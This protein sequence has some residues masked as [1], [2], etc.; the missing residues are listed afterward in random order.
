M[1]DGM[2][3][4]INGL[5]KI[6]GAERAL[7]R[8]VAMQSVR[9]LTIVS[10]REVAY[11][12]PDVANLPGDV[13]IKEFH[14][15]I[16]LLGGVVRLTAY[17]AQ[18]PATTV[19]CWMYRSNIAG[20]L[21]SLLVRRHRL[22][23]NVRHSLTRLE[24]EPAHVKISIWLNRALAGRADRILYNSD[25][26]RLQHEVYGFPAGKSAYVPNGFAPGPEPEPRQR[27]PNCFVI[28]HAGR[29]TWE[30]DTETLIAAFSRARAQSQVPLK[31]IMVGPGY[32]PD[33]PA[34]RALLKRHGADDGSVE[35]RGR[36]D[37]MLGFFRELDLF[38]LSSV[39]EGF[40]NVLAEA[41]LHGLPCLTTDVGAAPEIVADGFG[42][43][44][45]P[46][47]PERFAGALLM[48]AALVPARRQEMGDWARQHTVRRFSLDKIVAFYDAAG[49][50]P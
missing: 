42:W 4:I 46:Q 37:D 25:R 8:V 13:A 30:K 28:G 35:G 3:H 23:W 41:Q 26:A 22:I 12:A 1:P 7:L 45:P 39:S 11:D 48:A 32:D 29:L 9:P 24:A 2:V 38:A 49:N 14:G 18:Q 40:P 47:D 44:V 20:A 33:T 50:P 15:P 19:L 17:L 43:V 34:F 5:G 10:L 36:T 21:A 27:N 16:G 31:L 6:S